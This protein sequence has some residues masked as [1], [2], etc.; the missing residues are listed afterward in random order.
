MITNDCRVAT[1]A[2]RRS[3]LPRLNATTTVVPRSIAAKS[4]NDHIEAVR[5][6]RRPSH[7]FPAS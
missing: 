2:R 5:Q 6:P 7:L 3:R 1:L 4:H